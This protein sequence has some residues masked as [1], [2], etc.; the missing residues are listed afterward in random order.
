MHRRKGR[1]KRNGILRLGGFLERE[2]RRSLFTLVGGAPRRLR[3]SRSGVH[4]WLIVVYW[5]VEEREG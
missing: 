5:E 4:Y 3:I 1:Q 2:H